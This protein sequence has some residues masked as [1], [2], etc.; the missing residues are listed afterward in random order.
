MNKAYIVTIMLLLGQSSWAQIREFQTSRLTST[1]GTGVASVLST[2]AAILNPA[3]AAFFSDSSVSYHRYTTSLRKPS[4]EREARDDNFSTGKSQGFFATDQT[5]MVKG[6]LSYLKQ[7]END[8][9]RKQF[10]A[11]GASA[12]GKA[13]AMGFSYRYIEDKL[14]PDR[15]NRNQQHHQLNA[16]TLF[17]LSEDTTLA[18]IITDLTRTTP[19]EEKAIAGFQY[20]ITERLFLMGDAGFQYTETYSKKYLWRAA[21]QLN[22]FADFFIRAG[23]FYD[24]IQE[25]KGTGWGVSWIGPRLGVE[26]S[27]RFSDQFGKNSYIY[28]DESLAD[29]SISAIIK[30]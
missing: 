5:G 1:G 24:N 18:L 22:V 13:S 10:I 28:E 30:F 3:T 2:E 27:Q 16:G 4:T 7:D 21:L 15:T 19:N 14:P 12:I 26:F 17:A 25:F 29:T 6:G 9:E 23:Q 20:N 8:F 11:H